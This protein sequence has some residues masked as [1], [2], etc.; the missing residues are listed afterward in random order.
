MPA[1][2][3]LAC[4]QGLRN[5]AVAVPLADKKGKDHP[6]GIRQLIQYVQDLMGGHASQYF[7]VYSRIERLSPFYRGWCFPA[8]AQLVYGRVHYNRSHPGIERR[9]PGIEMA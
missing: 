6:C 3:S 8:L 5:F 9:Q 1:A 4:P 2:R 7:T